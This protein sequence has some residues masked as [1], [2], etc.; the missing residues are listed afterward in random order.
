MDPVVHFEI[1]ADQLDR[2]K[3]FYEKVFG[4]NIME[5]PGF[6]F[7]YMGVRTAPGDFGSPMPAGTIGGGMLPRG[8]PVRGVVI[9]ISVKNIE[10]A[11]ESITQ[12]GGKLVQ[13]KNPVAD[14]GFTA[15]FKD[16]EGNI[17]GLWEDA[18]K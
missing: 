1:P 7:R 11:L 17:I 15:Y 4:W 6:S 12:N 16:S 14:M 3:F 13:G 9:T 8:E 5:Y 2:A 10:D 18:K